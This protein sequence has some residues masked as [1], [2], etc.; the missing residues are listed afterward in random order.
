[1]IVSADN[2]GGGAV[3]GL[4]RATGKIVWKIERPKTPNYSS[5]IV[6]NVAGKDQLFMTGCDLVAGIEPMTGK[7]LWEI[8]GATTECVTSTVTDGERIFTSG[9]YPKNHVSA[10]RVDGS[11]KVDWE[12]NTRVYVPSMLVVDGHLY[13]VTDAGFAVCWKSDT[14][15]EL[16]KQRL[17]GTFSASLVKIGDYFLATNEAGRTYVFKATPKG[18]EMI[19][20]NQL[21]DEVMA[22]PIVCGGRIYMRVAQSEGGQRKETLYCIGKPE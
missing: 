14:G 22:T 15:K 1:V 10:V 17:G 20:E 4:D 9:G 19:G 3:A 21:G 7:I 11:G 13:A 12:N 18:C 8:K 6:Y 5:P 2:K 16:W